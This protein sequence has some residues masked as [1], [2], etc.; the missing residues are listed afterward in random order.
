ME[1]SLR[2]SLRDEGGVE[3]ETG[4]AHARLET[5]QLHINPEFGETVYVSYRD[6]VDIS[7]ENYR[8]QLALTSHETLV[9]FSLGYRYEDFRR[10]LYQRRNELMLNDLLITD[11][12]QNSGVESH[13]VYVDEHH[14]AVQRGPCELRIYETSIV[15]LP[16]RG[17]IVRVPF[18]YLSHIETKDYALVLHT[19]FGEQLTVS[20]L[21][22]HFDPVKTAL[23]NAI[24]ELSRKTQAYLHALSPAA[25]PTIL[26]RVAR[27]MKDGKAAKRTDIDAISPAFWI[28]LEQKLTTLGLQREYAFL[29]SLSQPSHVCI[30]VKRGLMG[31]LTGEYLWFLM[32][33]Y[34]LDPKTPGNAVALEAST[35]EGG[36]KA[37]YFFRIVSRNAY[38]TY[39]DLA[40]L[41]EAVDGCIQRINRCMLAINF[42]REPIYLSA[43]RLDEPRYVKYKFA[44]QR[45]PSLRALRQRFIGRILHRS[46][47]QW[48]RD[49]RSLLAFNTRTQDDAVKWSKG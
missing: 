13:F 41:R 1:C 30:G 20:M 28:A 43:E 32:P 7:E 36:G 40:A 10:A 38:G 4:E 9:L 27:L 39:T 22:R 14:E 5:E 26:R 19:D 12:L 45:L 47:E 29:H 23:S 17:A 46:P 6:V 24:H 31:D 21:G 16:E 8:L 3:R 44:V 15:V 49:V 18:S 25:T 2:Y 33:M 34:S 11:R 48:E 42:R 35:D 37:T